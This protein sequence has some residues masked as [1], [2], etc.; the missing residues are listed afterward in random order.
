MSDAIM[1]APRHP[2]DPPDSHAIAAIDG[3]ALSPPAGMAGFVAPERIGPADQAG[4]PLPPAAFALPLHSLLIDTPGMYAV[5]E[6]VWPS[7]SPMPV[8]LGGSWTSGSLWLTLG[9]ST[10]TALAAPT[11]HVLISS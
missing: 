7:G 11:P 4:P 5:I 8:P 3:R 2:A 10:P 9:S 1:Q 6:D